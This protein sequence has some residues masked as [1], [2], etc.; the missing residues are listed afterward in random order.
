MDGNV[1]DS[2]KC[3]GPNYCGINN[4]CVGFEYDRIFCYGSDQ[5]CLWNSNDC[6]QHSDC[7][8]YTTSSPKYSSLESSDCIRSQ[9]QIWEKDACNCKTGR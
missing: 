4:F 3:Y 5:G 6:L 2:H 8:K 7:S 1:D 9:L